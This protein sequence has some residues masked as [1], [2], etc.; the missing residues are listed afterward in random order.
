MVPAMTF[1]TPRNFFQS[2]GVFDLSWIGW[3]WNNIAAYT[4][5]RK[6]LPGPR[7][8]ADAEAEWPRRRDAMRSDLPLRDLAELRE[9]APYYYEWMEHPAGDPWWDWCE[10]RGKYDRVK[11][12]VLNLSGWHD[13]AYGPEGA[14]TNYL[15]LVAARRK[16]A[17]QRTRLVMGPWVHGVDAT[18]SPKSGER[19]FGPAAAI[20]YDEVV[21][22][23]LDRHVRGVDNGLDREKTVR[24]FVMGEAAWRE[25]DT[26]PLAATEPRTLFL[27]GSH[28]PGPLFRAQPFHTD[29]ML[30]RSSN[31]K[32][33]MQSMA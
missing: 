4:R 31:V 30:T 3:I 33:K 8:D 32:K 10:I 21:L 15:G 13:E 27:S 6:G 22:H 12:A 29:I 23:F 19:V 17:D 5:A 26:Y 7:T 25:A 18:G 16:D 1:S 2:G 11:A 28:D 14:I 20:D 9:V 24:V